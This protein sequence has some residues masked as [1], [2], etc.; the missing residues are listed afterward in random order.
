VVA[1][2]AI[3]TAVVLFVADGGG[4]SSNHTSRPGHAAPTQGDAPAPSVRPAAAVPAIGVSYPRGL[5]T[6]RDGSLLISNSRHNQILKR[7]ADGSV[8]LFAGTGTP[9]A[10]GDGGPAS[11]AELDSPEGLAVGPD[12]TV[13]IADTNNGRVRAVSPNGVIFTLARVSNPTSL[14]IDAAGRVWVAD[15]A[16]LRIEG[17]GTVTTVLTPGAGRYMVDGQ[18]NEFDGAGLAIEGDGTIVVS[19]FATKYVARIAPDGTLLGAWRDYV[20]DGGLATGPDGTV[21][22][23][24]YGFWQIE[25][26]TPTGPVPVVT[27]TRDSIPGIEGTFRPE[28][29]TVESNGTIYSATDG[30]GGTNVQALI[31]VDPNHTITA[32]GADPLGQ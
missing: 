1:V 26:I 3:A 8:E 32:L 16:V 24:S 6:T 31:S 25:R 4:G 29:L 20:N 23:A 28:V 9:G 5:A 21:Y 11:R 18:P 15:G 27:F 22:A 14:A 10:D 2:L 13:Y 17:D 12:G 30:G 7:A 19:S